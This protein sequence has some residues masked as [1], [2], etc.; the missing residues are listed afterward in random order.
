MPVK[1][2]RVSSEKISAEIASWIERLSM[3]GAF[4]VLAKA[5]ALEAE[6]KSIIHLEIGEPDFDTPRNIKERAI[7]AINAGETHYSPASGIMEL[8]KSIAEHISKTRGM[9][10]SPEEVLVTPG[11]KPMIFF[12]TMALVQ[13]GHQVIIPN[14]AYPTYESVV[15]FIGATPVSIELRE[16]ED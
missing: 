15:R 3:E 4:A 7:R 6:R 2:R 12:T 9:E 14:P 10:V 5:R 11:S 8:R 1:T 16:S 13:K